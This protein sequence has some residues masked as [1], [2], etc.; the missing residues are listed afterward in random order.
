MNLKIEESL[1][2]EFNDN[3][4]LSSLFGV[5]D[6]NI[7]LLEKINNVKIE[8]RGNI[9]KISGQKISI[10]ETKT[11][12]EK[13]F[14]EAKKGIEI[15]EEKIRDTKSLISLDINQETQ[16]DLFIQ[17]KKR[18]IIPRSE[19]QK[20]YFELLNNKDIVFAIGPAGTGKT[21]LAVAKAVAALQK[22]LVKK[23]ILSR[24]AV[25]AGEKLGFLPGDLKEKVDPFLRPIYDALYDMMPYD[26]VEKKIDNNII[27]IAPI[28]FMRGRTHQDCF[29]ILDEAQNT[30][31]IQM[32]MFL[33]RLGKNSKMVIVGDK[34]QIDLVSKND[35][36]LLDA[37]K[38]LQKIQDIG[39]IY[40][41][42]QDVVR[43]QL[44]RKIINA[45]EHS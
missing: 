21:Y 17:T 33:T 20:K 5:S 38:Q 34:T 16:L 25:E 35:S 23:I 31:R 11:T 32:K 10:K 26:Q 41:N 13:L 3:N 43:H 39:F 4:I 6:K 15:D 40:L 37:E 12:L 36:G 9:V 8:Y 14:D 22:G 2:I 27:E 19:N 1:Q 28:A 24:P 44:V 42:D 30:T 7:H 29:I 18:K 45:Y